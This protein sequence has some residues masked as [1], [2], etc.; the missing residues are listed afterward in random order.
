MMKSSTYDD[1]HVRNKGLVKMIEIFR[2]HGDITIVMSLNFGE[3][4]P[5]ILLGSVRIYD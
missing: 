5:K 4:A 3:H 1:R 2:A